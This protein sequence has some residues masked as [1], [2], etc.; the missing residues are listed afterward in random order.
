MSNDLII[1]RDAKGNIINIYLPNNIGKT[2]DQ[3]TK[4]AIA[5]AKD[6]RGSV[7]GIWPEQEEGSE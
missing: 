1:V 2:R 4:E 7:D 3:L 6:H 5:M